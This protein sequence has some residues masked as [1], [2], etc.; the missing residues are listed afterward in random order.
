[1]NDLLGVL[2]PYSTVVIFIGI[3]MLLAASMQVVLSTG[4][5]SVG[6]I[7]FAGIGAYTSAILTVRYQL[8]F[9]IG[10]A[11]GALL[12][13]ILAP[14][15]VLPAL[16]LKGMFLALTTLAFVLAFQAFLFNA[17]PITGGAAGYF[18]IRVETTVPI[19]AL[20]VIGGAYI[21]Y[22]TNSSRAGRAIRLIKHDAQ[23]AACL[24]VNVTYYRVLTSEVS[25]VLA[26][27]SGSLTAHYLA[28]ISPDQFGFEAT[29][30]L[31]AMVIVGGIGSWAGSYL[32]AALL[33]ALPLLL[34]ELVGW[35]DIVNGILIIVVMVLQPGGL[36]AA[37][38]RLR[39][40]L[41]RLIPAS[42]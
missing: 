3:N 23:L 30:S 26:A 24:G 11:G 35:A 17:E 21:L 13:M 36:I 34:V 8:P 9:A 12:S 14:I 29:V 39:G 27:L 41:P 33:T 16:R 38:G 10:L 32:G 5:F 20:A 25:A 6:S 7:A 42:R 40:V 4:F 28:Y 18:R 31:L 2:G 15:L 1:L 22:R 37:V 19:V